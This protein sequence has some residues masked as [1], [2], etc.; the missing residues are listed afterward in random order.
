MPNLIIDCDTDDS[1]AVFALPAA[2]FIPE[3]AEDES[4]C[5]PQQSV[6]FSLLGE[7]DSGTS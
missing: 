4:C 7:D 2:D 1:D 3:E 6:E 5:G